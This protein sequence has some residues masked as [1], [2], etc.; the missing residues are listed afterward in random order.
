[1]NSHTNNLSPEYLKKKKFLK[2]LGLKLGYIY[3]FLNNELT[4][5]EREKLN[6]VQVFRRYLATFQHIELSECWS[7]EEEIENYRRLGFTLR[8]ATKYVSKLKKVYTKDSTINWI[9]RIAESKSIPNGDKLFEKHLEQFDENIR[10]KDKKSEISN[11]THCQQC[12]VFSKENQRCIL[13]KMICCNM[14][15]SGLEETCYVCEYLVN[16]F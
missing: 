6:F 11:I 7:V 1:M 16:N 8:S 2:D 10:K 4:E 13:C 14:C 3:N 9:Y 5:D 12:L 15:K